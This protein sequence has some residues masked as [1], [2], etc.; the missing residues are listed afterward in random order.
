MKK[1]NVTAPAG[2][3]TIHIEREFDA[4]KAKLYKAMSTR[5]LIE[6]WWTGPGY[7]VRVE[8]LEPREG[9]KWRYVQYMDDKSAEFA[10]YG[11]YHE[12]SADRVV[13]SFEFSGLPER[14][15]VILER[16]QMKELEGGRTLLTVDQSFFSA[17]DRDGMMASGMEDGMN[18]TYAKLEEL[19]ANLD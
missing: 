10:F 18:Q 19:A 12:H 9:G 13:Q 17:A 1:A 16:M 11:V 5:E 4:P 2:A 3:S 14:G 7:K 15:H 8:E 6:K